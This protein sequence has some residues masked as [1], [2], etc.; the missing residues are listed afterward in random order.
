MQ[1]KIAIPDFVL[2]EIPKS[3]LE[4]NYFNHLEG[5]EGAW[6]RMTKIRNGEIDYIYDDYSSLINTLERYYKG[7]LDFKVKTEK[8]YDLD[9]DF[10]TKDHK[11]NNFVDE[12]EKHFCLLSRPLSK[13]EKSQRRNFLYKLSRAYVEARYTEYHSFDDFKKLYEFVEKQREI[14]LEYLNPKQKES[15][16][17]PEEDADYTD[18]EEEV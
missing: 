12:I 1:V 15:D 18:E 6:N 8:D 7:L 17:S 3:P 13:S 4:N 9:S 14:I 11:L 10:L 16:S 2:D 5:A